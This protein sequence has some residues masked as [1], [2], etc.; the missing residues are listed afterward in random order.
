MDHPS[1]RLNWFD[2]SRKTIPMDPMLSVEMVSEVKGIGRRRDDHCSGDETTSEAPHR[3]W[4]RW[5]EN[6]Y[7][8]WQYLYHSG[9][10]GCRKSTGMIQGE[11]RKSTEMAL[12]SH[13]ERQCMKWP[14]MLD[15]VMFPFS[16]MEES[17]MSDT[18]PRYDPFPPSLP[19]LLPLC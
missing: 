19:L 3:Q 10:Y 6:W 15:L 16:L 18:S 5:I 7:G 9:G 13:R 11:R 8:L 4:S 2:G 17:E 14:H 12:S 1:T